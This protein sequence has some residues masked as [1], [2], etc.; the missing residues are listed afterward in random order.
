MRVGVMCHQGFDGHPGQDSVAVQTGLKAETLVADDLTK[1]EHLD[2]KEEGSKQRAL[3]HA[4]VDLS[5]VGTDGEKM[6]PSEHKQFEIGLE[7]YRIWV[8]AAILKLEGTM[9]DSKEELIF[10]TTMGHRLD[11]HHDGPSSVVLQKISL[12]TGLL[13]PREGEGTS[14]TPPEEEPTSSITERT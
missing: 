13:S 14:E 9:P 5:L 1:E 10:S 8:T 2:G 3:G 7:L 4:L 6:S 11:P 12:A